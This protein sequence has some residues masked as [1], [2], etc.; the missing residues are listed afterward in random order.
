MAE[1]I[2]HLEI[3]GFLFDS[4]QNKNGVNLVVFEAKYDFEDY[5]IKKEQIS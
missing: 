3:D 5:E 1:Y 4:S 2:W